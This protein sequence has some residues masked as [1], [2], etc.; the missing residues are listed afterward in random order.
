MGDD[1]RKGRIT[2]EDL[3][4]QQLVIGKYEPNRH[5]EFHSTLSVDSIRNFALCIGSDD[6]LHVDEDHGHR[7]RWGSM[8]APS[9]MAAIVNEP[10]RGER[11]PKELKVAT[12]GLFKGCQIF[13]SGGT[14]TWY[15]P[16]YPGDTIYSYEGEES[17]EVKESE[18]GGRTVHIT[19]RYVKFNQRAEVVGVYRL[20]RIIAERSTARKKAKYADTEAASWT[21]EQIAEIDER[22]LAEQPRSDEAQW[23]EDVEVGSSFGPIQKGPLTTTDVMLAHAAGYGFAPQ[24]MLATGRVAAKDRARMPMMYSPNHLGAPDTEAR[25]HWDGE[26]ARKVGNPE[27]YDWGLQREFWL[28]HALTDFAGDDGFV[29]RQH[30]EIRKFNYHGDLQ[31]ITGEVTD[32][33]VDDGQPVVDVRVAAVSQRGEETAFAE[34]TIALPSREHGPVVLPTVPAELQREAADFLRAHRR[35]VG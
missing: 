35:A 33:R 3:E 19:R 28:H 6:P 30:D 34:A 12:R 5:R 17:L 4:A 24:R 16:M 15:R 9:I 2:D 20:L 8:V 11:L 27:A 31:T 1:A 21:P 13:M 7:S 22:Y 32:R 23:F 29:L 10:L 26:L 25:V 14:W 18:F